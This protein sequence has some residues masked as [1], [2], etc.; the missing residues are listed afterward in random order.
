MTMV[1][2]TFFKRQASP[3]E[4][5]FV[6]TVNGEIDRQIFT[7]LLTKSF[8]SINFI[9]DCYLRHLIHQP[10]KTVVSKHEEFL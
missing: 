10:R 4:V 3:L 5:S 6:S 1:E 7:S 8:F 2:M 9:I